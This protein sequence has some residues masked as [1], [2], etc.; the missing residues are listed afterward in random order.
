MIDGAVARS[1]SGVLLAVLL[2]LPALR[3]A[4]RRSRTPRLRPRRKSGLIWRAMCLPDVLGNTIKPR[5]RCRARRAARSAPRWRGSRR[6]VNF[7]AVASSIGRC[8]C[9]WRSPPMCSPSSRSDFWT[10]PV[11][12]RRWLRDMVGSSTWVPPIR[13]TRR[14][15][16][17]VL[18]LTLVS[19]RL[20]ARAQRVPHAGSSR[21]SKPRRC[22]A[23]G[24]IG[25]GLARRAADGTALDRGGRCARVHGDAGRF[26]RGLRVQ[27]Q[28]VHDRDLSGLV[29]H[30]LGAA[31]RWSLPACCCC[32]CSR[33]SRSS[34]VPEPA[35]DFASTRE[36]TSRSAAVASCRCRR[37]LAAHCWRALRRVRARV[38]AA[39]AATAWSGPSRAAARSGQSLLGF[40]ARSLVLAG[41][42][43]VVIVAASLLL[44]YVVRR[45]PTR[46]DTRARAAWRRMGYAIPGTVLAVGILVPLVA[47]QQLPAGSVASHGSA[48]ARRCCC[49]KAHCW[50][51]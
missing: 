39:G 45:D 4:A 19:V 13:S 8:C 17:L 31:R 22:W 48:K 14:R 32:S 40:I 3:A 43:A 25:G 11:R 28:H 34:D 7:P 44:A 49:C 21:C 50:R 20:S 33:R 2:C 36:M 51:C 12:C 26:R 24:R 1:R 10:T 5:D 38:R 30:V 27:L 47:V 42:A 23:I 9:R 46:F 18:S 35:R 37:A 15:R 6:C 16:S 41:S 29:R